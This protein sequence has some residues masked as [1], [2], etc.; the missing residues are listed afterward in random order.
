MQ[1]QWMSSLQTLAPVNGQNCHFVWETAEI[2]RTC[3]I[4][5]EFFAVQRNYNSRL[6]GAAALM[7]VSSLNL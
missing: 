1:Q 4:G 3:E 6:F 5:V 2:R 7:G